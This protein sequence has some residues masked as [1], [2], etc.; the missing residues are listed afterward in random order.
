MSRV[1]AASSS[2]GYTSVWD[3]R[4]TKEIVSLQYGGGAAKGETAHGMA[5]LQMGKRRGMSDVCWHPDS[6]TRLITSSEDDDSPIIMLWDLRNTR[7]PERILSGHTKGVLSVA[8]CK[9]DPDLLASCGKDN[10]TLLWNPQTGDIVGEL[11]SARDWSF[12]TSWCPSNPNL[13]ATASFD[14]HIGIN[15]L[16]ATR[17]EEEPKAVIAEDA[18]AE[19]VFGA[20]AGQSSSSNDDK[21]NVQ[22]LGQAPKWMCRPVSATFGYG[23]L[24][25]SV[26]NLPGANGKHQSGVVHLRNV[27]TEESI[28]DRAKELSEISSDKDKLSE[29]SATKSDDPS[30]K[31]LQTLFDANSRDELVTLLGFSK[32]EVKKQ[33]AE[34]VKKYGKPEDAEEEKIGGDETPKTDKA[35]K[36]DTPTVVVATDGS[37]SETNSLFEDR[38]FTPATAGGDTDFFAS[39]ASGSLRNPQLNAIIPHMNERADSSVA[40]TVG[41]GASSLRSEIINKD[42]NFSIYPAG[43]SDVDKLITQALVL[44]DFASAVDLCVASDRF[45]DALLLAV[46]GGPELLQ[47]TQKAYFTRRTMAH[48]FLRVFQSIVTED[49][50][51]IVQ[52]ADLAEW[53]V[54]FVVLCTFAKDTEFANLADQLGQRLQ[55]K[56]QLLAASDSP[57][58]KESAKKARQDATLCYLAA[59]NLEHVIS[60]WISEM[61]EEESSTDAP[62]YSAHA[63]AL[64]SFIEKVTVFRAA[65]GYVDKDL[66]SPAD[67][68][69]TYALSGL[70]DRLHEYADLLATQGLV[71]VAAKYVKMTPKDYGSGSSIGQ[72]RDRLFAAAGLQEQA[73]ASSS[74]SAFG[75][76]AAASSSQASK[77]RS[78]GRPPAPAAAS[79]YAAAPSYGGPSAYGAS[80]YQSSPFQAAQTTSN[81]YAP[82][83]SQQQQPP[84]P[85]SNAYAPPPTSSPY[86]ATASAPAISNQYGAPQTSTYTPYQPS[87]YSNGYDANPQPGGYGAPAPNQTYQPAYGAT[88]TVPPPP[89]ANASAV[90]P[91]AEN[92]I[93]ASQRRDLPGWN[94]APSMAPPKRPTPTA[95]ESTP[96]P[97]AITSPFPMGDPSQAQYAP[98]AAASH[99]ASAPPPGRGGPAPGVLPP[100][101]KGG[102]RPQSAAHNRPPSTQGIPQAPMQTPFAPTGGPP[103]QQFGQPPSQ[104]QAGPP[105]PGQHQY[106]AAPAQAARPPPPRGS[107]RAGPPPP[108]V[109][110]GPPP[111]ALSPLGPGGASQAQPSMYG[112]LASPPQQTQPPPPGGRLA[113]PPPPGRVPTGSQSPQPSAPTPPP[114]APVKSRHA[115]GDRSHIPQGLQHIVDTLSGELSRIK[116][117]DLPAHVHRIVNDTERRLNILF[118]E[119]NNDAVDSSTTGQLDQ[120]SKAIAAHDPNTAL[121]LHVDLAT[122][123]TGEATHWAV[124]LYSFS[125]SERPTVLTIFPARCEAAHSPGHLMNMEGDVT[126]DE[127]TNGVN[128]DVKLGSVMNSHTHEVIHAT[129]CL[130]PIHPAANVETLRVLTDPPLTALHTAP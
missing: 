45:A 66:D 38:P 126:D 73:V 81:P 14:G 116:A 120:I 61:H 26:S 76:A 91:L 33:V 68:A 9:Q 98:P 129:S 86:A 37:P 115:A 34:A 8:W 99:M 39:M 127:R 130:E 62:R 35:D 60:I 57:E 58:A 125:T 6:P 96:K 105:P 42:N 92:L 44:G 48:P 23:G 19:D 11:P 55:F 90:S 104:Y 85:T 80:G 112:A 77:V 83:P 21:F 32:E 12:Q 87:G 97:A 51:D 75:A 70:Y 63:N 46:R 2:S 43:E 72:S 110:A 65:T 16:Q 47:S 1:F 17:A 78:G 82:P 30:W 74:T 89:R 49:L 69:R 128:A 59:R 15:S 28:I 50:T 5:A 64:Q 22:S 20:L 4:A 36:T 124:S 10:R 118:D 25:T 88:G 95:R 29:F 100:P 94:D 27:V 52:N 113:G 3:L 54:V 108:G 114:A 18:S 122:N 109:I 24:L 84:A 123:A 102:P 79:P 121:A 101:P 40:A 119:L 71:D 67:P 41:S 31:A 7:A 103:P 93:P 107:P 106:G 53:R 56:W 13:L 111:R 117:R